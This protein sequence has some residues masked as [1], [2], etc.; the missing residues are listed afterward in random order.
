MSTTKATGA[1]EAELEQLRTL[2]HAPGRNLVRVL[3]FLLLLF[4]GPLVAGTYWMNRRAARELEQVE[5]QRVVVRA[6]TV[7]ALVE[8][9][10]VSAQKILAS[11]AGRHM[12]RDAW[13][14]RDLPALNRHFQDVR[15]L[16]PAFLFVSVYE[17]DGTMRAILPADPIVGQNFSYRDWY[18]GVTA[19]WQPYFSEVYRTAA[20]PNPLVVA[21]A[22]PIPD[23]AGKP[24]GILMATYA[25]DQLVKKFEILESG[26]LGASYVVD[27][28]GV[29]AVSHEIDPYGEPVMAPEPGQWREP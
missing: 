12:F 23:E 2:T 14:R 17:R 1:S 20:A 26:S 7:A 5:L 18:R 11:I 3:V 22:V 6:R 28:R 10:F 8:R 13:A 29:V 4:I 25:L 27:Q 16:E 15:E 9:E 21:V 24:Q 19:D